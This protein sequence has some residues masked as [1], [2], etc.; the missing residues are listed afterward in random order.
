MYKPFI[1]KLSLSFLIACQTFSFIAVSQAKNYDAEQEI[2]IKSNRQAGDLKNKIISYLDNVSITQG[3]LSITA[4][5]VQV[6][7]NTNNNDT[8]IAKGKPATFSQR[9]EDGSVVN[10]EA[11]VITYEPLMNTITITGNAVLSQ[12]GSEVRGSKIIYNILTEQLEAESNTENPVTTILK[13]RNN[14]ESSSNE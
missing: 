7:K 5:L 13:P 11:D 10:L 1:K 14:T 4:D 6:I 9:L 8:Y 2:T 3:S 12:E